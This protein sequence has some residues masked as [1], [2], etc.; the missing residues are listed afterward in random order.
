MPLQV[1]E[2]RRLY[3]QIADQL[4]GLIDGGEY[5][6]GARLPPERDL[7]L[8]L[9]VSRPSVREALIAL[10]VEGRVE[11]RMGSG[12]YVRRPDAAAA[13]KPVL[14]ESPLDTLHARQLIERE[15]AAYAAE[16]MND[17]QIAGLNAAVDAMQREFDAGIAPMAGDKLFHVRIAEASDNSVLIRLVG[18]LFDERQNPLSRQLD[19]HFQNDRSWQAT[20][21]E[22]R[23]VVA[24]IA[25]RTPDAARRAMAD[26]LAAVHERLT[27]QWPAEAA[28]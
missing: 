18:E 20:I 7:A 9:G 25:S 1:V 22:H 14:A 24:A 17:A 8:Q 28:A 2:S 10:E 13:A 5:A 19:S 4:R 27:A 11:V 12:I 26:H 3:R 15:L 6:I 23:A 21:A 16:H